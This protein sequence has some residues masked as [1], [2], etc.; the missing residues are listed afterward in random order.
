M[1]KLGLGA[2][3]FSIAWP[4]IQPEGKGPINQSGLDHYRRLVDTLRAHDIEPLVTL[5]H[6]D[7][8]QGLQDSGGWVQRDTAY[9]FEDYARVVTEALGDG[10]DRWITLNEPWCSA[11]LGYG[12]GAHAPGLSE[13]GTAVLAA[14]HLLL[15]HGLAARAIVETSPRPAEIGIALNLAPVSPASDSPDDLAAAQR[16]HD[17]QNAWFLDPVLRGSYPRELLA[18]Y[19]RLVGDEFVHEGDL[20]VIGSARPF[21]GVNYYM[22]LRVAAAGM[23]RGATRASSFGTW[24]GI[25][26]RA[27]PDLPLSGS[28]WAIDPAG[29][30]ELLVRLRNDYGSV[31]LYITENGAAF[32]DYVDPNGAVQDIERIEYLRGHLAAAHAAIANGVDLRGYFVWSVYDN[33]EWA[34]GYAQRFGLVF[35]D[36]RTQQRILKASAYWYRDVIAANALE[37]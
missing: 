27:R 13:I 7:L 8:P 18:E 6:W 35:T 14:H 20:E 2:Y 21:V 30:F 12:A 33:F 34:H 28:G 3:R 17:Q 23:G 1:G 5:Y 10:V 15:S 22:P 4:R 36:F 31:P 11:F 37:I 16:V 24:L 19:V 26:H 9:R 29:L 32:F 25:E